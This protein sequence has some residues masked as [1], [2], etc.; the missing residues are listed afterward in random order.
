MIALDRSTTTLGVENRSAVAP[1]SP[2]PICLRPGDKR[3][4]V[5]VTNQR[6]SGERTYTNTIDTRANSMPDDR[7][8]DAA[9]DIYERTKPGDTLISDLLT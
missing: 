6:P 4:Y 2:K 8:W 9:N 7:E 1:H 3:R 5:D